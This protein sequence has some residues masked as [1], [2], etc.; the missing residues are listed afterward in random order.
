MI[1]NSIGQTLN[2]PIE[3]EELLGRARFDKWWNCSGA[4]AGSIFLVGREIVNVEAACR[5][6]PSDGVFH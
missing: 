5:V 2:Q 1:L 3:L 4:D 6:W